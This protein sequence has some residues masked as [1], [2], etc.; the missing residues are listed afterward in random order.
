MKA[1][2]F[3]KSI[4]GYNHLEEEAAKLTDQEAINNAL[5]EYYNYQK[6][7]VIEDEVESILKKNN[8]YVIIMEKTDDEKLK[9]AIKILDIKGLSMPN[10]CEE[11]VVTRSDIA[12][13]LENAMKTMAQISNMYGGSI[14]SISTMV[15]NIQKIIDELPND[16]SLVKNF[17]R[18]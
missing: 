12:Q 10:E 16:Y 11:I 8:Y 17:K 1:L 2:K 13:G 18:K 15:K 4:M 5:S 3:L 14:D 6:S 7:K 9:K